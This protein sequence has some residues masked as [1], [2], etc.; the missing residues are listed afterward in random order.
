MAMN[1][2]AVLRV[3]A[4]TKGVED[5][6]KLNDA[7]QEVGTSSKQTGKN[8]EAAAAKGSDW[9]AVAGIAALVTT[10]TLATRSS[11]EFETQIAGVKK[12]VD[13]LGSVEAVQNISNEIL[14]L[15]K[16]L[17]ITA[18]GFAEIYAAAGQS[19]IAKAQLKEFSLLVT[20]VSTA[21]DL[22]A[23]EAGTSLA[24]IKTGL[25]LSIPELSKLADAMNFVEN[26]TGATARGLIDF[27]NRSGAVGKIAGL[28]ATETLS[29]GAAM[30]QIGIDTEV[31]STSF[32]NM[33]K[34]LSRG[35]SM[36]E[37]QVEALRR[38]GY[39]MSS[40]ADIEKRLTQEAEAASRA[41]VNAYEKEVSKS[42][43]L[44]EK[45]YE[46]RIRIAEK[47]TD[48][49]MQEIAIR[50]RQLEKQA[51]DTFED[52]DIER[53]RMFRKNLR[54]KIREVEN[55]RNLELQKIKDSEN[56]NDQSLEMINSFYEDKINALQ[57]GAE[58]EQRILNRQ[59]R[60]QREQQKNS[61]EKTRSQEEEAV[62]AKNAL[63]QKR[64][65]EE[66]SDFKQTRQA[67]L[68][69][70][71]ESES[72]NLEIAKESA[73]KTGE[74]MAQNSAQGFANRLQKDATATIL[75]VL[76]KISQLPKERQIS[77][78]SDL[79]GDEARGLAPLLGNLKEL[80]RILKLVS[81]EQNYTGSTAAEAEKRFETAASKIQVF[82]NK[83]D[84]LKIAAG[85]IFLPILTGVLAP[86]GAIVDTVTGILKTVESLAQRIIIFKALGAGIGAVFGPAFSLFTVITGIVG[87]FNL[88]K[89]A[90]TLK[91]LA[92]IPG[93]LRAISILLAATA[94]SATPLG[95]ALGA[96]ST[97]L[98]VIQ[99]IKLATTVAN[100]LGALGPFASRAILLMTPFLS[101]I[102]G[103]LLP[104][105]VGVFSGPAGWIA[106]G[107]VALA[108]IIIIWREPI[109][110]FIQ[111]ATAQF[112][113][114]WPSVVGFFYDEYLEPWVNIWN[115]DMLTPIKDGITSWL[116]SIGLWW[117]SVIKSASNFL[118]GG[119][120]TTWSE[121]IKAIN[122]AITSWGNSIRQFFNNMLLF[123]NQDW[124]VKFSEFWETTT[125]R[126]QRWFQRI[127]DSLVNGFRSAAAIIQSA[128]DNIASSVS[129]V[130]NW[131]SQGVTN[132]LN[133]VLAMYNRI[134]GV[135]NSIPGGL[136]R[137]PT[138]QL[139][140]APQQVQ[141]FAT[142]GFVSRPTLGWI[143]EGR[144]GGEYAI[145]SHQMPAAVA[146]WAQGLRGQALIEHSRS[147]S[148]MPPA[149]QPAMGD[150]RITLQQNGPTLVT[151][152]GQNWIS[153][154]EAAAMLEQGLK[155]M[156]RANATAT[157]R[158]L[159]S[160]AGRS[161]WGV[162]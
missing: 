113:G 114:F 109:W 137:L 91:I 36:T 130:W 155:A 11:V 41:R 133:N 118:L 112:L 9:K 101:W 143:G 55:E 146:G 53:E 54:S 39:E 87:L 59:L 161:A 104:T 52:Q 2:D 12:V 8:L 156:A 96:I 153:R 98:L 26:N 122:S 45:Q 5:V 23:N 129:K 70:Y 51:S 34:A 84:A 72:K 47:E 19:G 117:E 106:L 142:G 151:P 158:L 145:P 20:N 71:K 115:S 105:L 159:R 76:T 126:I 110:K 79:F 46:E 48:S 138:A 37:R 60:D 148:S 125:T 50:Y 28:S 25:S 4:K 38:L 123:I 119:W 31:A 62:R 89:L 78:L 64:R 13:G 94:I 65:Q 24:Q 102:T 56:A 108:S 66:L 139:V 35:P 16:S 111:W 162:G 127:P 69:A 103:T 86:L 81:K 85:N 83:L 58:D 30:T 14:N 1:L 15:S 128:Y 40:A 67:I 75:E 43:D 150:L 61:L 68:E 88:V 136:I 44:A 141:A 27:M 80:E 77:V 107:V 157:G 18:K 160:S 97:A 33:I 121:S 92:L 131:I 29:F 90:G 100:W 6:L 135:V 42:I 149:S 140:Q 63:L 95:P 124:G 22:T 17:P 57:E 134:A 144:P 120:K 74:T 3:T 32:N 116:A 99:G 10:L 154:E 82:T 152:D 73:K 132:T 21:F 49:L 93:P 7:V 147:G